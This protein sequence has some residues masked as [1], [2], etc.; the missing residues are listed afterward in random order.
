[1]SNISILPHDH[2]SGCLLCAEICPQKCIST[3]KDVLGFNYPTIDYSKCIQCGRC[4]AM[5]PALN[6]VK[7]SLPLKVFAAKW[8]SD[9]DLARCSSGGVASAIAT[10]VLES[11]GVYYG[12]VSSQDCA[13]KYQRFDNPNMI[14]D[15]KGSK[16][17]QSDLA[18]VYQ[19]IKEDLTKRKV[20]FVGTPCQCAAIEKFCSGGR[21]NLFLVSFPCGGWTSTELLKAEVERLTGDWHCEKVIMRKRH[22]VSVDVYRDGNLH[23]SCIP[24]FSY[25]MTALDY[26]LSVRESCWNCKYSTPERPG[27]IV[28]GDYWGLAE[29]AAFSKEDINDGVSFVGYLTETGEKLINEV[30]NTM[31]VCVSEYSDVRQRNPRLNGILEHDKSFSKN[32]RNRFLKL[33][34]KFGL[35][36][37]TILSEPK[38]HALRAVRGIIKYRIHWRKAQT[39]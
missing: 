24:N 39:K 38:R 20:L 26:K 1:M 4:F 21:E 31:K 13:I 23:A 15:A 19:R 10:K 6:S 28:L 29:S 37:A 25:F 9:A 7:T 8:K 36:M 32:R 35:K 11:G 33:Y 34:P 14:E 30:L 2:C 3:F 12:A 27:D 22:R 18:A 17:V 16:Y 5:C